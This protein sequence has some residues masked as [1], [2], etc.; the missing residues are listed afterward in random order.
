MV[1]LGV[2]IGHNEGGDSQK[3]WTTDV[4]VPVS[5]LSN[6]VKVT[7]KDLGE[8]SK[9]SPGGGGGRIVGHVG[10]GNF[11]CILLFDE[12]ERPVIEEIVHRMVKRAIEM[13]GTVTDYLGEEAKT[14][15]RPSLPFKLRQGGT[16]GKRCT[17]FEAILLSDLANETECRLLK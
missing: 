3:V 14:R 1:G 5:R 15:I 4:A 16:N 2:S 13:E 7:K 11:H 6:I 12:R 8:W 17:H 9:Q 10:D